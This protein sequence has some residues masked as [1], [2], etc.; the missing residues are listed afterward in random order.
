MDNIAEIITEYKYLNFEE[1]RDET[2]CLEK[3]E[4]INPGVSLIIRDQTKARFMHFPTYNAYIDA[5]NG[6]EYTTHEVIMSWM[7]QK[8]KFDI[9]GG[10]EQIFEEFKEIIEAE[11]YEK[12]GI[13]PDIVICDSSRPDKFSR[14]IIINNAK[15]ANANEATWFTEQLRLSCTEDIVK[16][17]DWNVNKSTQNFRTPGSIKEGGMKRVANPHMYID[18]MITLFG[19]NTHLLPLIAPV[20]AVADY[21]AVGISAEQLEIIKS[22]VDPEI[23]M[24]N[25]RR[26]G[27]NKVAFDR[28]KRSHCEICGREHDHS[29]IFVC[30]FPD[31]IRQFCYRDDQKRSI[32]LWHAEKPVPKMADLTHKVY[33]S[34][35]LKYS[36]QVYENFDEIKQHIRDT[37]AFIV[38]GGNSIY[39][40]KNECDGSSVY[41][42]MK[43]RTLKQSHPTQFALRAQNKITS[44][45][46]ADIVASMHGEIAYDRIDFI[47]YLHEPPNLNRVF[48]LFTGFKHQYDAGFEVEYEKIR[49]ICD[50]IRNVWCKNN[51]EHYEYIINWFAHIVQ[52]PAKKLGVAV[53]LRSL[54]QGTGKGLLSEFF[55]KQI[56]GHRYSIVLSDIEQLIGK[57]NSQ[58]ENKLLT[59]CDEIQNY[60]GAHKSND[61]LKSLITQTECTIERK[62][63]DS[64]SVS[65][66]NNFMFL[67]NNDWIVKVEASDRRYFILDCDNSLANNKEYFAPLV[68]STEDPETARHFFHYLAHRDLSGWNGR[69]IPDSDFKHELKLNSVPSPIRYLID[70]VKG[71]TDGRLAFN[72]GVLRQHTETLYAHF[73]NWSNDCGIIENMTKDAFSKHLSKV[74]KPMPTP[75]AVGVR[76]RGF[77]FKIDETKLAVTAFMKVGVEVVF[78]VEE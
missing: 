29:G 42:I 17:V 74:I 1:G 68:S 33:F 32:E 72:A 20:K 56:L 38:N 31:S 24:H 76:K 59:I 64:V 48:N 26:S 9:D 19:P 21:T 57:F 5:Y 55:G 75:I 3:C 10:N 34:D 61:K 66:Y 4:Q 44:V 77:E 39:V 73:R 15:F 37:I 35:Y 8:P 22:K 45:S 51:T 67:T 69:N 62:G 25:E 47:P 27:G 36:N 65:D 14:H 11:F 40:T 30:A 58:L 16:C 18:A 41:N 23:W 71:E 2:E 53:I 50:H 13:E 43:I 28:L 6:L 70:L 46:L 49:L 60:G 78:P 7:E 54:F 12:Y 52:F 63:V